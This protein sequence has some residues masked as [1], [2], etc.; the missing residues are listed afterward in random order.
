MSNANKKM[1]LLTLLSFCWNAIGDV[2]ELL[3]DF[4]SK[5]SWWWLLKV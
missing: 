4:M 5:A 1:S 2:L 3:L